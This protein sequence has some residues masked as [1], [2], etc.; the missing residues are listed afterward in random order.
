M[1]NITWTLMLHYY[2]S[3]VK[4]LLKITDVPLC[5]SFKKY[6]SAKSLPFAV[7]LKFGDQKRYANFINESFFQVIVTLFINFN[8][9]SCNIDKDFNSNLDQC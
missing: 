4:L 8:Q 6:L 2:F 9:L 1:K 7:K 3:I 5:E